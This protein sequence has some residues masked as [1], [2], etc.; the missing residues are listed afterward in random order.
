MIVQESEVF[1]TMQKMHSL[2]L[3]GL[4]NKID[5]CNHS[6]VAPV[7]TEVAKFNARADGVT[8]FH[9]VSCHFITTNSFKQ[10]FKENF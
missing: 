1:K 6:P 2:K 9:I 3:K 5:L 7:V 4:D 10:L 8:N